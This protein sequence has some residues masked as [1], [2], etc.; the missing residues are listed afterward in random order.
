MATELA[1]FACLLLLYG[2]KKPWGQRSRRVAVA[3]EEWEG[4]DSSHCGKGTRNAESEKSM[5]K[6]QEGTQ[7]KQQRHKGRT[8]KGCESAKVSAHVRA[9][10]TL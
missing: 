4:N 9:Q 10:A 7:M 8:R 3:T 6:I 5:A 1:D 2:K